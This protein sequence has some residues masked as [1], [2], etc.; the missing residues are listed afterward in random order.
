M[1]YP[2]RMGWSQG[3]TGLQNIM[4]IVFALSC[5]LLVPAHYICLHTQT[6]FLFPCAWA[7]YVFECLTPPPA[8]LLCNSSHIRGNEYFV[9]ITQCG[10]SMYEWP[11]IYCHHLVEVN[12]LHVCESHGFFITSQIAKRAIS[13]HY[14]VDEV[15]LKQQRGCYQRHWSTKRSLCSFSHGLFCL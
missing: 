13:K 5:L 14:R 10:F 1:G 11:L 7:F 12:V 15:S 8:C 6:L 3:F 4:I 2:E 9:D